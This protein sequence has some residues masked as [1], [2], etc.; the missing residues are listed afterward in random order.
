MERKKD[1]D[2][3]QDCDKSRDDDSKIWGETCYCRAEPEKKTINGRTVFV[4]CNNGAEGGFGT[5]KSLLL[6]VVLLLSS[7]RL[8]NGPL[9]I[10]L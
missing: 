10:N 4:G 3:L 6:A 2:E 5:G 8:F 7:L 9:G 1:K